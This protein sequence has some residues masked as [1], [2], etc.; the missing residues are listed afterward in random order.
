MS[1]A[2]VRSSSPAETRR[3]GARLGRSL[4]AADVVLLSG[5]LGAGKTVFVAGIARGLGVPHGISSKSFVLV[6]EYQGRIKLHHADLYRLDNWEQ[7]EEL[8]LNDY[9]LDGALV[10]EWPERAWELFP[11][12]FLLVRF[13]IWEE[14]ERRL[15]FEPHGG[16]AEALAKALLTTKERRG[17]IDRYGL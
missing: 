13:E 9:T 7:A 6:G 12:D 5:E 15:S 16:R 4:E 8:G 2:A 10:V 3:W 14:R 1:D 11:S 17:V